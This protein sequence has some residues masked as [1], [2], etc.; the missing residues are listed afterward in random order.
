MIFAK[1]KIHFQIIFVLVLVLFNINI[2][3][4]NGFRSSLQ[5][6]KNMNKINRKQ[7]KIALSNTYL[8][9]YQKKLIQRI[10]TDKTENTEKIKQKVKQILFYKYYGYT[11]S[12]TQEFCKT[13]SKLVRNIRRRELLQYAM[14][15]LLQA[16]NKYNGSYPFHIY[17]QIYVKYA[18]YRAITDC[19]PICPIPHSLRVN[20]A[21]KKD[22]KNAI[23]YKRMIQGP[24][25]QY[26]NLPSSLTLSKNNNNNV[27]EKDEKIET[28]LSILDMILDKQDVSSKR[29][30][31]LLYDKSTLQQIRTYKEVAELSCCSKQTVYT[32]MR[33]VFDMIREKTKK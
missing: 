1:N 20:R 2:N 8:T 12:L 4:T 3:I 28:I 23:Y 26:E 32:K 5:Q 15:G 24:S 19:G 30:F 7:T 33:Y 6:N 29:M 11:H 22:K 9:T 18:L 17:L 16:C 13:H 10:L 27:Y 31:A 14:M 21:W 25:Y